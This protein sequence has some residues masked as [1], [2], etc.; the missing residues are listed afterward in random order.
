MKWEHPPLIKIYEALG[1]VADGR[2]EVSCNAVKVYSSSGNKYYDVTYSKEENAIMTNDNGSYWKGY[3]GYPG[4]AYLLQVGELEYRPEMGE[5][6]KGVAWK[7]I[8]QKYKND[9]EKTLAE[10]L[11]P[12]SSTDKSALEQYVAK[13]DNDVSALQLEKLG[14][15]TLPPKGY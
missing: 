12:L 6:L 11:E 1:A 14:K 13:I 3:L 9:F 7:D 5:L 8:N 10:I 15:R 2:V 4:I